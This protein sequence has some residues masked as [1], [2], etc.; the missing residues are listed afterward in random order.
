MWD[1]VATGLQAAFAVA[2]I[3]ATYR[4]DDVAIELAA[5][6]GGVKRELAWGPTD[7]TVQHSDTDFIVSAAALDDLVPPTAGDRL[8]IDIGG[9]AQTFE[10]TYQDG[11]QA[12]W[13]YLPG[14]E[15]IRLTLTRITDD[16]GEPVDQETP[17]PLPELTVIHGL[18]WRIDDY[19]VTTLGIVNLTKLISAGDV[20]QLVV[21][22]A[23]DERTL[24]FHSGVDFSLHPPSSINLSTL[25]ISVG[26]VLIITNL[27]KPRIA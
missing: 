13:R 5:L 10:L 9:R 2:G 8:D 24:T 17:E 6:T 14:N 21:D 7:L 22:H 19:T 25:P 3:A 4:R 26:D 27:G 12:N 1:H 20:L 15:F 23:P 16:V 11:G 18:K